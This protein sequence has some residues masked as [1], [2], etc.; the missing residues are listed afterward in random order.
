ML[1]L[2]AE[3]SLPDPEKTMEDARA[4]LL[5]TLTLQKELATLGEAVSPI[6]EDH[7]GKAAVRAAI[8]PP[9]VVTRHFEGPGMASLRDAGVIEMLADIVA[10][11][12][13]HPENAAQVLEGTHRLWLAEEA[14]VRSLEVPFKPHFTVLT[15]VIADLAR[16]VGAGFDE[17]EWIA[18]LGLL[19][20]FHAAASDAPRDAVLE[21]ARAKMAT[22]C[23]QEEEWMRALLAQ[24]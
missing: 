6:W 21:A 18:S 16:K 23:A 11:L 14:P 24:A 15:L 12:L 4:I 7:E 2:P 22:M 17:L 9:E 10:L 8:V 13:E 19:D 5:H 3:F 20:A 1:H